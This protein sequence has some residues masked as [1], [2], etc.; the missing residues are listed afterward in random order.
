[1]KQ[2]EIKLIAV[3]NVYI[4]MMHFKDMG[5]VELGH[6]HPYDHATLIS[7]GSV[8]YEQLDD[9]GTVVANKIVQA[10]HPIFVPKNIQH[11][12]TALEPNTVAACIHALRTVESD[13][14]DP[15]FFLEPVE[16][17]DQ[18]VGKAIKDRLGET[19]ERLTG[20]DTP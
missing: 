6:C 20:K 16:N 2:P 11:R 19:M 12:L 9:S 3:S 5:D 17:I 4:R 8:L 15:S 1:M 10:P 14:L 7:S 13:L 18:S